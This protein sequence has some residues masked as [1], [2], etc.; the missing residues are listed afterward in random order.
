MSHINSILI[1]TNK[2][3]RGTDIIFFDETKK[4]M[5]IILIINFF[6]QNSSIEFQD[7]DDWQVGR[8]GPWKN[9]NHYVIQKKKNLFILIIFLLGILIIILKINFW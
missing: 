4:K 5:G 2:A 1:V 6:P 9:K 8:Q 3:E 7:I